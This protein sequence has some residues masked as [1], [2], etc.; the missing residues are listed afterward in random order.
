MSNLFRAC[1]P[2]VLVVT[3]VAGCQSGDG[4]SDSADADSQ[5]SVLATGEP[6]ARLPSI[7]LSRFAWRQIGQWKQAADANYLGAF[8]GSRRL[9]YGLTDSSQRFGLVLRGE[10]S[11]VEREAGSPPWFIQDAWLAG[12]TAVFMDLHLDRREAVVRAYGIPSVSGDPA[13]SPHEVAVSSP[14]AS[15][16]DGHMAVFVGDPKRRQCLRVVSV[17]KWQRAV[18]TCGHSNQ[19]LGDPALGSG[20]VLHSKLVHW[21]SKQKRCK[22]LAVVDM[23]TGDHVQDV[24][25]TINKHAACNAWSGELASGFVAWDEAD[26]RTSSI[27]TGNLFALLQS[28]EVMDLGGSVTGSAVACGEYLFWET[29]DEPAALMAWTP[30]MQPSLARKV[31]PDRVLTKAQCT[32]DRWLTVRSDDNDGKDE[33]LVL[34]ALDVSSLG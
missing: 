17:P 29:T 34:W 18:E 28:G 16:G 14:E 23:R 10:K 6:T 30:G 12:D 2:V 8:D 11:L 32:N 21:N 27:A 19:I 26:P 1:V 25:A 24:E 22:E 9:L 5:P 15:V 7:P 33:R 20:R 3:L 4:G 31:E 13:R